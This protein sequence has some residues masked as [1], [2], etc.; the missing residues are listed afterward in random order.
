[1]VTDIVEGNEGNV[2]RVHHNIAV[3]LKE[4]GDGMEEMN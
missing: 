1:M 3:G 4:G 2:Q